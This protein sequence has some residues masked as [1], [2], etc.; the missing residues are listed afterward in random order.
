MSDQTDNLLNLVK[1]YGLSEAETRL[2]FYLLKTGFTTALTCS[3][4]LHMG[5]TKVYRLLDKLKEKQLVEFK[6]DERGMKFGATSPQKFKQLVTAKEQEVASLKHS[7][8]NLLEQL[9]TL[10]ATTATKSKVLYYEGVEGLK[11]VSYNAT[12]AK[13][14]LRVFEMEH[15]SD[16][17]PTSFAEDVRQKLVDNKVTTHDLTNKKSFPG[18]TDVKNAIPTYNKFRHVS[19]KKLKINF[20][21]LIYNDVYATYTYKNKDIFCV[22]VHNKELA[23]MQKQ[24]FDYIWKQ[25]I[26]M[27]IIDSRGAARVKKQTSV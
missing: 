15:L 9:T 20:E 7:L 10:S 5:R 2:Y 3:R 21:V 24:L 13:G 26:K 4:E 14:V 17:L 18:F 1:P 25:S 16:F 11:Q 19:P 23:K 6:I 22:E 27:E 8:P 12:K